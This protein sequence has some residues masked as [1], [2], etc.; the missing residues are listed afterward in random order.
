[1]N[2]RSNPRLRTYARYAI[3]SSWYTS[4][5]SAQPEET[6]PA[7]EAVAAA[8]AAETPSGT[9]YFTESR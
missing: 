5:R 1:M 6:A 2:M 8:G 9:K 3:S 4:V 7:D